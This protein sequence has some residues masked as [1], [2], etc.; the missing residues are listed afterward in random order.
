[1]DKILALKAPVLLE[2]SHDTSRFDCGVEPLNE[3]LVK[4][5]YI[6]NQNRSART[7]VAT[8]NQQVVGYYTLTPGS[9]IRENVPKRV[10]KGLANHPVPVI[11]IARLAVDIADRGK[12]LG[13]GLLRNAFIRILRASDIIGGRA[14]LVHAKDVK[15]KAF[16]EHFGF[17]SSPIDQFHLYL[18]L[19]DIKKTVG[20]Q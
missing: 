19:K 10:S 15:A 5:A 17:E 16:Y 9:I 20:I 2:S 13:K 1:M 14:V 12:G 11:I 6:N 8:R 18:L 7:Y 4:F 3:Y